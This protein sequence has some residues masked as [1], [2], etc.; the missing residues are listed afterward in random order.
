[1]RQS[2]CLPV[3]PALHAMC[4]SL[5]R[6]YRSLAA[7]ELSATVKDLA[8]RFKNNAQCN[9]L[10]C[11]CEALSLLASRKDTSTPARF[12]DEFRELLEVAGVMA[13][14]DEGGFGVETASKGLD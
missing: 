13:T 1:M 8:K 14:P 4:H 5:F 9:E 3:S 12:D 2:S 10:F 11:N 7:L 6:K